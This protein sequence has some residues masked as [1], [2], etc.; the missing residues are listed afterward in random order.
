MRAALPALSAVAYGFLPVV[1]LRQSPLA[2]P[3]PVLPGAATGLL[4]RDNTP[5]TVTPGT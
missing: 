2:Y 4:A 1:G 5:F 3:C